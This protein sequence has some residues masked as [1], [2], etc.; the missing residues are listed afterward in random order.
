MVVLQLG[1]FPPPHGGVQT[2]LV[3]IRDY[4]RARGMAAPVINLTRHRRRDGDDVYYPQSGRQVLTL[5]REIPADIIHIHIGGLLSGRLLALC[6]ICAMLPRRR[7]V[8]TFHSGGYPSKVAGNCVRRWSLRGI[9]FRRLDAIIAVNAEIGALFARLG[10]S[11]SRI[12]EICPYLP[13]RSKRISP[14]PSP[15]AASARLI[16]RC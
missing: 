13:S 4:L 5:L 3:A 11:P 10:V 15:S 6:A 12:H 1:P 2:N 14:S 7:V 8:L 9:V 16:R